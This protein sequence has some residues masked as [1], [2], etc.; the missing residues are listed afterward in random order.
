MKTRC[1]RR[2]LLRRGALGG[3][4]LV[5]LPDARSTGSFRAN[6]KVNVALVGVAGRG[7][8]F[9]GSIPKLDA[10]VVAMCD[11][12]DRK[13]GPYFQAIPEARKFHDFRV[14]LQEMDKE[15]DAVVVATPDNTHAVISAAAIW[16][17]KHVY[18]EKP[19]TH[20]IFEARSLKTLVAH[21][22][23]ASR[24]YVATQMGNQGTASEAFRRSVEL[25]QAGVLGEVRE[26]HAWNT[27]GGAGPRPGPTDVHPIP[28]YIHWDVWLGPAS[29][30]PYNSR[31]M[32]W[33]TWRDFATGQL[34]NWG[35]HTMNVAFKGLY[36]DTLWPAA[37]TVE[38][39]AMSR[40]IRVEPEVSQVCRDTFPKWEII[41]FQFPAR[42]PMPPVTINWYNGGGKAPGPRAEIEKMMG[43]PL[44]WGDAGE[45]RW[46]D[47][48]GCL[49]VGTEGMLH[50]NGHNTEFTLLPAK[51][52]E[53]FEG[54][55]RSLPRSRGHEREW[56]AACKGEL[57]AMS[58]F[59]YSAS[60]AEFVLLGNVAT[61]VGKAIEYDPLT[62][63]VVNV[64]EA[65]DLLRRTYRAGWSL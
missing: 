27:G 46:K 5:I 54:P 45:K 44:D 38:M 18:C 51:K 52:F 4:G 63:N 1:T 2:T 13:A 23:L 11:T 28:D 25:I 48:A 36:L 34:G 9:V 35:C 41:R 40:I 14:M 6:E 53:G 65:N 32:D 8:W 24:R 20:D 58:N 61:F 22:T 56:L 42:G 43:R 15:I 10:N 17:G 3:L 37:G 21:Q 29:D 62:M 59:K 19:L 57:E 7:S 64:P 47:H 49:L 39:P 31:W 26:V 60:L 55:A 16:R 33:H 30:R 12:N 50:S